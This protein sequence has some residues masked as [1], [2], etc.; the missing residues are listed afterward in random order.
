MLAVEELAVGGGLSGPPIL[1]DSTS[2][3]ILQWLYGSTKKPGA[4][5]YST[6]ALYTHA[7]ME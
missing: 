4:Y 2:I 7:C 3:L 1:I 6:L 5:G